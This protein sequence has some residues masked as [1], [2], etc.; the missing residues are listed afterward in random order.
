MS[1]QSFKAMVVS[2]T[3]RWGIYEGNHNQTNRQPARGGSTLK[4]KVFIPE[5]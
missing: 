5:L 3:G 2:K 4:R 1:S